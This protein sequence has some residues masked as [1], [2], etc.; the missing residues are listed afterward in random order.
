MDELLE[1]QRENITHILELYKISANETAKITKINHKTIYTY[2]NMTRNP[3]N[4]TFLAIATTF[5]LS[6][7]WIYGISHE[8]YTR[9]S[10]KKAENYCYV[11]FQETIPYKPN[12]NYT[13]EAK[14]NLIVLQQYKHILEETKYKRAKL[15]QTQEEITKIAETGNAIYKLN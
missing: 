4:R 9:E 12:V 13:L 5:G 6:L 10:I 14:A 8:P 3:E 1:Q 7:D 11:K 15:E 2:K